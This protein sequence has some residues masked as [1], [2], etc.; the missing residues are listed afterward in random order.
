M[1]VTKSL[2]LKQLFY[3]SRFL[4]P[5]NCSGFFNGV[6]KVFEPGALNYYTLF[7]LILRSS[8]VSRNPTLTRLL[9]SGSLDTLLCD[10]IA[11][12]PRLAFFPLHP[13]SGV[14]IFVRQGLSFSKLSTSSFFLL[15]SYSDYAGANISLN[16]FSSLRFLNVYAPP[17]CTSQ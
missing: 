17:I 11:L 4:F 7:C 2:W 5:S 13:S 15:D 8:S 9:L 6:P 16:N 3:T 10:L 12:T 1:S 14:I